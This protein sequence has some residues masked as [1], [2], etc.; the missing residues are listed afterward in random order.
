MPANLPAEAKAKLAKYSEARTVE[1][2]IRALEEF[3]SSVPKHKGTE[4]IMLWARRRLAELREEL[5]LR[6]RKRVGGGGLQFFVEKAGVAQVVIL[7]PPNVGKSSILAKLTNA[8]PEISPYPYTTKTPVPGMLV[9]EDVQI[10][11]VDTP[12]LN[13]V[14]IDSSLNNRVL[15]LARNADA[16]ILVFS[17]DCGEL[18]EVVKR[19]LSLLEDRGIVVTRLKGV[20]RIKKSR[21]VE[22][23]KV[24]GSGRLLGFTEDELAKLLASYR[25]FNAIVEVEGD[26]T[27]DDVES[28]IITSKVYKPTIVLVNK[29]DLAEEPGELV[30]KVSHLIPADVPVIP[31]SAEKS[32]GLKVLGDILFKKLDLIRV[33]TKSPNKEPDPNP[34]VVKR[35]T[36][37][38]E[39]AEMV[40]VRLAK[41]FKYA[42]IWGRSVKYPGQRVG[43]EHIL[44]DG[45]VVEI[46]AS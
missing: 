36:T 23:V 7:G 14:D 9:Y 11:L 40:H 2:K 32:L 13:L 45:D 17:V 12:P 30:E 35:G 46:H 37:V 4:N 27:L 21:G 31:V 6:K 8:K 38:I 16:I 15:G 24:V 42:K 34:L 44:E 1:E 22:G 39:V 26:V 41:G 25:I 29:I 19:S 3:I 33:Y 18:E 43:A 20:V 5:E 28:A 10:Q